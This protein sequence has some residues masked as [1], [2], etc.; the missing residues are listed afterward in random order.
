[1]AG[2]SLFSNFNNTLCRL[3]INVLNSSKWIRV[4]SVSMYWILQNGFAL[5]RLYCGSKISPLWL[6]RFG[7]SLC[8]RFAAFVLHCRPVARSRLLVDLRIYEVGGG[9]GIFRDLRRI[10][11]ELWECWRVV[12]LSAIL[13]A[14]S[15]KC[16]RNSV[17]ARLKGREGFVCVLGTHG[18]SAVPAFLE[19]L[20]IIFVS[21][22]KQ[23]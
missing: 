6:N 17:V 7:G 13:F 22:V 21:K 16:L 18:Y 14:E 12:S 8:G 20:N 1:M 10:Y 9:G 23:Y 5:Y 15:L 11:Q 4:G 2:F 19:L 3:S